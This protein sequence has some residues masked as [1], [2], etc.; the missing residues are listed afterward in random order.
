MAVTHTGQG[1]IDVCVERLCQEGCS[2]VT[3]Y[4]RLLQSGEQ[5]PELAGLAP[6]EVEAVLDELVS[7]MAA[8]EG[9]CKS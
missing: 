1:R 3:E 7:V 4:I 9:A 6:E 2:K 8:Y 5:L